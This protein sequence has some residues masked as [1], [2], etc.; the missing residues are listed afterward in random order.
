MFQGMELDD[1]AK[2]T[3]ELDGN[4]SPWN[5]ACNVIVLCMQRLPRSD[6]VGFRKV[7]TGSLTAAMGRSTLLE[8]THADKGGREHVGD[9]QHQQL[10]QAIR[11]SFCGVVFR[12]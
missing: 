10:R 11:C 1:S 3:A 2:E 9:V 4:L 5:L 12:S 6:T 8:S 7:S